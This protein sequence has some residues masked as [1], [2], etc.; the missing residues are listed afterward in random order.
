MEFAV[1]QLATTVAGSLIKLKDYW[2]QVKEVPD[3]IHHLLRMLDAYSNVISS[4]KHS[5][6]YT[7]LNDG[8][9]QECVDLCQ[10][11]AGELKSVIDD[12]ATKI[13]SKTGW[14]KRKGSVKILL[15]KDEIKR[16]KKKMKNAVTLLQLAL[17]WHTT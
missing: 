10:K 9:I 17:S 4:I 6:S 15:H 8:Y 14:K 2:D 16:L 5:G 13:E 7:S 11:G 3:D 1:A 12:M